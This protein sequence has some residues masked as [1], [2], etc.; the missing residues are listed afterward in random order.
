MTALVKERHRLYG[1]EPKPERIEK[2]TA[3][4]KPLRKEIRMCV[5]IEKHSEEIE[6]KMEELKEQEYRRA[7]NAGREK[8][9]RETEMEERW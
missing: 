6:K 2:I 1:V 7:G 8:R 4:L 5:K 3:E 9:D